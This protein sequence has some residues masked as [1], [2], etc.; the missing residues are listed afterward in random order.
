MNALRNITTLIMVTAF[1]FFGTAKI[2]GASIVTESNGWT[3]L[4]ETQ[5][6]MIGALELAA[7]A[8]LLLALH[9]RFR[10]VGVAAASGLAVLCFSA[11][12]YHLVNADPA[13]DIAPAI[14]QGLVATTYVV[15]ATRSLQNV[16]NTP[17]LVSA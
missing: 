6:S 2:V 13:G 9:P 12:V 8:G 11:V 5:W 17:S 14:V 7:V 16:S 3:R 15:V 10:S 1:G 4:S